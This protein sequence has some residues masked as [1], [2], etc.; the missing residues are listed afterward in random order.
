MLPIYLTMISNPLSRLFRGVYRD[1][2]WRRG[3]NECTGQ[4]EAGEHNPAARV[5]LA[6]FGRD[7]GDGDRPRLKIYEAIQRSSVPCSSQEGPNNSGGVSRRNGLNM[8]RKLAG[9]EDQR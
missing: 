1:R 3:P 2:Q 5:E 8:I 4:D 9:E 6:L 7:L